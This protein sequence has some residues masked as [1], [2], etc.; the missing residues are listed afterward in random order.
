MKAADAQGCTGQ[1]GNKFNIAATFL[2]G[3]SPAAAEVVRN[4]AV[5]SDDNLLPFFLLGSLAT[6]TGDGDEGSD[7]PRR[8]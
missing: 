3:R 4:R 6:G 7:R 8:C 2:L 5:A 1:N